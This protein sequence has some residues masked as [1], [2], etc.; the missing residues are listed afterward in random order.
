MFKDTLHKVIA[1]FGEQPKELELDFWREKFKKKS[2]V[3]PD[4]IDSFIL[5]VKDKVEGKGSHRR[6]AV[7]VESKPG[8]LGC[9]IKMNNGKY[10]TFEVKFSDGSVGTYL[11]EELTILEHE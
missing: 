4:F 10:P 9:V 11:P 8:L 2:A 1:E 7:T 3:S 6:R 5:R